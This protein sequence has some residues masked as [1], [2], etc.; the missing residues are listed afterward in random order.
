MARDA[1]WQQRT[2]GAHSP[3][4]VLGAVRC[5][6]TRLDAALENTS[7]ALVRFEYKVVA[8]LI[9]REKL[10]AVRAAVVCDDVRPFAREEL[11]EGERRS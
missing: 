7:F 4:E 11:K 2:C 5:S 6:D 8:N 10:D 1:M 9:G 3:H